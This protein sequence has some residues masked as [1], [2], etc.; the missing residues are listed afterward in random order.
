[1]WPQK[2]VFVEWMS[3][4]CLK[5]SSLVDGHVSVSPNSLD[6]TWKQLVRRSREPLHLIKHASSCWWNSAGRIKIESQ[7]VQLIT[8]SGDSP[9]WN[10]GQHCDHLDFQRWAEFDM[11]ICALKDRTGPALPALSQESLFYH[12]FWSPG[13]SHLWNPPFQTRPNRWNF[14]ISSLLAQSLDTIWYIWSRSCEA[15]Q[16]IHH[17]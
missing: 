9:A 8:M 17:F 4:S 14:C 2:H 6:V 12:C 7:V 3:I 1:M 16:L 13:D 15:L 10:E 11:V 5:F